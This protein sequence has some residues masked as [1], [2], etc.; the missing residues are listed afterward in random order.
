MSGERGSD[1]CVRAAALSA[2]L[3]MLALA[4]SL[5]AEPAAKSPSLSFE[6]RLELTRRLGELSGAQPA[7]DEWFAAAERVLGF[8]EAGRAELLRRVEVKLRSRMRAYG[9]AFV[10]AGR[11]VRDAQLA[12]AREAAGMTR[13]QLEEDTRRDRGIVLG[14]RSGKTTKQSL[15][16]QATPAV[17]RLAKL[18]L[19]DAAKVLATSADLQ[20]R[21]ERLARLLALRDRCGGPKGAWSIEQS[22]SALD[23]RCAMLAIPMDGYARR[24]IEGNAALERQLGIEEAAGIRELNRIR[25][26]LGLAALRV[27]PAL[28]RAARDHS[29][30]M[31]S[32]KFFSH[33]SPVPGKETVGK[34]A[35]AAGTRAGAENIAVGPKTGRAVIRMWSHSPGHFRNM[36]GGHRR[37]GL[38]RDGRRWTQMFGR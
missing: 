33:T 21:R 26:L 14:L 34:R 4:S 18:L 37:V 2:A 22:L 17:G 12:K 1:V 7:C 5:G 24:T 30:D 16:E 32:R 36:L 23:E 31:R 3:A 13:L 27:D 28:C 35:A 19:P 6:Q 25:L 38:G 11:R 20:A 10:A 9:Q 29:G 8:G 15:R